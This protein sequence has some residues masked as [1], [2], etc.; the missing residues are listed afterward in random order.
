MA[1]GKG[2]RETKENKN[3]SLRSKAADRKGNRTSAIKKA[4]DKVVPKKKV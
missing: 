4:K 2:R 1:P 3:G